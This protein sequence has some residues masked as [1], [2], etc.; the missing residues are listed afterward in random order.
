M[1]G[2]YKMSANLAIW[3]P[4][5]ADRCD[6]SS[7]NDQ[8]LTDINFSKWLLK[9]AI[10]GLFC[11]KC[12][13]M[14]A[15]N[16][17]LYTI[18]IIY[19]QVYKVKYINWRMNAKVYFW[20]FLLYYYHFKDRAKKTCLVNGTDLDL[21]KP[22]YFSLFSLPLSLHFPGARHTDIH[23]MTPTHTHTMEIRS[24]AN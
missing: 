8:P 9:F 17:T 6:E 12:P 24:G 7:S 16:D 10:E 19:I 13:P 23:P 18:H 21:A 2:L 4:L 1:R 20:A 3:P 22:D 11:L 5:D 15:L 14:S